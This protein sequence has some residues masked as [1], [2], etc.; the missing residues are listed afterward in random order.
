MA[1]SRPSTYSALLRQ[2]WI[3]VTEIVRLTKHKIYLISLYRRGLL[4]PASEYFGQHDTLFQLPW[5]YW[6]SIGIK[7]TFVGCICGKSNMYPVC[8]TMTA[9]RICPFFANLNCS[10]RNSHLSV[11]K[12]S[13][14]TVTE[15]DT[16][17]EAGLVRSSRYSLLLLSVAGVANEAQHSCPGSIRDV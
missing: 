9:Y 5:P 11:V 8:V 12:V 17:F 3:A 13:F 15:T 16:S 1:T 2:I 10:Y 14:S 6:A 7:V 4:T